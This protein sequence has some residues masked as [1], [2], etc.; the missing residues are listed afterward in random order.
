MR[1]TDQRYEDWRAY[2][3]DSFWFVQPM[4]HLEL[5]VTNWM[6]VAAS[7]GYRSVRDFNSFGMNA[8]D[9]SGKMAGVT[10]RFGSW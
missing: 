3:T 9:I 10:F 2:D 7:V 6:R 1:N 5:N 8:D 4:V